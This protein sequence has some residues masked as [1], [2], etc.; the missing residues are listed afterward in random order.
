MK[1]RGPLDD[2]WPMEFTRRLQGLERPLG[3]D[4]PGVPV[5]LK[6]RPVGGCFHREDSPR[7]YQLIDAAVN[8]TGLEESAQWH[9][10]ESG[11]EILVWVPLVTAGVAFSAAVI[12]LVVS[13]LRARSEGV[14]AGDTPREPVELIIRTSRPAEGIVEEKVLRLD[15]RDPVHADAIRVALNQAVVKMLSAP[16]AKQSRRKAK[17]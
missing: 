3:S 7:A 12:N 14:R 9:E 4:V 13:I 6:V 8:E 16:R 11:P 10:H 5:S 15:P 2:S 17:K 1:K